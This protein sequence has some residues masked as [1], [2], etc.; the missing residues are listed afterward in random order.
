MMDKIIFEE[1]NLTYSWTEFFGWNW[2]LSP[3]LRWNSVSKTLPW[4]DSFSSRLNCRC[5]KAS[6]PKNVVLCFPSLM[7][8]SCWRTNFHTS[9][10]SRTLPMC[11]RVTLGDQVRRLTTPQK[12]L[13]LR[14]TPVSDVYF[15]FSFT[16][17]RGAD[18]KVGNE[19]NTRKRV[20][21]QRLKKKNTLELFGKPQVK[22][23]WDG[24][25]ILTFPTASWLSVVS[26]TGADHS[27]WGTGGLSGA[28]HLDRG[29]A[30]GA[31]GL[32]PPACNTLG[33]SHLDQATFPHSLRVGARITF[34][35]TG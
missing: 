14:G 2:T 7:E 21:A 9:I 30:G 1:K 25:E 18:I 20:A 28:P 33:L 8:P 12:R 6:Y 32:L 11:G 5:D 15:A 4:S 26:H 31:G 29:G 24:R 10:S 13:A 27:P 22:Q 23:G 16:K 3:G 19:M 34:L 17:T 35:P